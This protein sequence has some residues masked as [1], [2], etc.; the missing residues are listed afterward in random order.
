MDNI[1]RNLVTLKTDIMKNIYLLFA[2]SGAL[3]VILGAFGAHS[4]ENKISS[5]ELAWFQTANRY[6]F[7]HT[8]A[9]MATMLP[10]FSEKFRHR[11]GIFFLIGILFFSGSLY[12]MS[13]SELIGISRKWLGPITPIGGIFFILG[14]ISLLLGIRKQ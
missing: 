3:A 6:H 8:L 1:F 4:L 13:I 12:L 7:Y 9:L 10:A 5:D 11:A 14:W 2:L